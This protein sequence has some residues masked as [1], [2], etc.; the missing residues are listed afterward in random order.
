MWHYMRTI[1]QLHTTTILHN[2]IPE[3]GRSK[4]RIPNATLSHSKSPMA[5]SP[6]SGTSGGGMFLRSGYPIKRQSNLDGCRFCALPSKK[7]LSSIKTIHREFL[8]EGDEEYLCSRLKNVIPQYFTISLKHWSQSA[9]IQ[10]EKSK[11]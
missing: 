7:G 4:V 8:N 3:K 5:G 6:I 2:K 1:L 9:Q 11:N 10:N